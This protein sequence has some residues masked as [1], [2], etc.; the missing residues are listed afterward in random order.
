MFKRLA[1]VKMITV[2]YKGNAQAISEIMGGQITTMFS[3]ALPAVQ[4][5]KT[6]KIRA[7]AVTSEQRWPHTPE[8]PT[9]AEE[10]I[11]GF[12]AVNW[13]GIL[14]PAG[15]P[16]PIVDKVA[17]DLGKALATPGVKSALAV[18]GVE[19]ISSTPEQFGAF[20]ASE[21]TRWGKLIKE[22]GLKVE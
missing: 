7:L 10:G 15:V 22:A 17:A 9:L 21:T 16:R 3:D 2:N 11:K 13:W 14:F 20:M 8:L 4:G 18:L 1:G 6:G 12:A 19:A 5:L